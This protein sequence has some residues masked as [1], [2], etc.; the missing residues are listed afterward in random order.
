MSN[1]RLLYIDASTRETSE[2]RD[3]LTSKGC[4]I[5]NSADLQEVDR[6]DGLSSYDVLVL[7]IAQPASSKI[8]SI[9]EQLAKLLDLPP[10]VLLVDD[11]SALIRATISLLPVE[12]IV[13]NQSNRLS[14]EL[15]CHAV[16]TANAKNRQIQAL[17]RHNDNLDAFSDSV[18]HDLKN[19]ITHFLS[20][21]DDLRENIFQMQPPEIDHYLDVVVQQSRKMSEIIDALL[22]FARV[23]TIDEVQLEALDMG[24]IVSDSLAHLHPDIEAQNAHIELPSSWPVV[25]GYA[26]WVESMWTNYISNGLKY[27]GQPPQLV[28]G[29]D[30]ESN[31]MVRFWVSDRGSG[32]REGEQKKLFQP[33]PM[34]RRPGNRSY[35]LGLVIVRRIAER[36]NGY[37]AVESEPGKGSVFSF[38][39]PASY[40]HIS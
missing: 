4:H 13:I 25:Y 19:P 10:L 12:Q 11:D 14:Q 17:K 22:L 30:T 33:F 26:P 6:E 24:K 36:L 37:V 28:I 23:R 38:S 31:G 35:G 15:L 29:A 21:A 32:F 2:Q 20:Y 27:G 5:D 9:V 1:P 34:L 3:W 16:E 7:D 18:A 40:S 39:L 8:D